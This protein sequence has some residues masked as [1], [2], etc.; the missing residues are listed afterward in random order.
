MCIEQEKQSLISVILPTY[1]VADYLYQCLESVKRQSY[2][3]IEVIIIIDGATD[4]S[5]KIA[6]EF[7][8]T[9]E[10][11]SVYWQ[12]NASTG[13]ARAKEVVSSLFY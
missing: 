13:F 9:D 2:S 1:N 8:K 7:C 12:E 3:N 5:Y 4:D 11:F 6:K 10:R